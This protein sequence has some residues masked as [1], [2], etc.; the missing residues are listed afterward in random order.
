MSKILFTV[1]IDYGNQYFLQEMICHDQNF[2]FE[3]AHEIMVLT[4]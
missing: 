3:P 2:T 4:T 1:S